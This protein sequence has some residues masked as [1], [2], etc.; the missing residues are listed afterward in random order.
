MDNWIK[1]F[2][3]QSPWR[4]R[5]MYLLMMGLAILLSYD[6]GTGTIMLGPLAR[7]I[8]VWCLLVWGLRE[9]AKRNETS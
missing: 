5:C 2:A 4:K 1:W 8:I 6:T 9:L 7:N 3:A